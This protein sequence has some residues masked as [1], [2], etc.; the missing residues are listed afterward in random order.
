MIASDTERCVGRTNSPIHWLEVCQIALCRFVI[1]YIYISDVVLNGKSA[2]WNLFREINQIEWILHI[3]APVGVSSAIYG[4]LC[5]N[6]I[7]ESYFPCSMPA[8]YACDLR[9]IIHTLHFVHEN[10]L[11]N[12]KS[13]VKLY[14][15][16][17]IDT[18]CGDG[19]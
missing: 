19:L 18:D 11:G 15:Y 5:T 6:T 3:Y 12:R 16:K 2:H 4:D 14:L 13:A 8:V 7:N 1:R 17:P 10:Y 9:T